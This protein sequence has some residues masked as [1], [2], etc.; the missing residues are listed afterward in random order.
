MAAYHTIN[1]NFGKIGISSESEIFFN[2]NL[3]GRSTK[4]TRVLIDNNVYYV[5]IGENKDIPSLFLDEHN[6]RQ[7]YN[8]YGRVRHMICDNPIKGKY[9]ACV[10]I[11]L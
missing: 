4:Y 3:I 6:C 1:T 10:E 5:F 9:L 2:D 7:I 11:Q 8:L